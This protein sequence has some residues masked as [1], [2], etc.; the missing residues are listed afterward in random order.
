MNPASRFIGKARNRSVAKTNFRNGGDSLPG[1][2]ANRQ[3]C[4]TISEISFGNP[5][6]ESNR[7]HFTIAVGALVLAPGVG[8]GV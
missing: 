3:V 2:V 5:P 8:E 4:P 7:N 1:I 6:R